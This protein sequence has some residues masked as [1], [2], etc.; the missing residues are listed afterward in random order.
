MEAFK[1]TSWIP[2]TKFTD[3]VRGSR[4]KI[5]LPSTKRFVVFRHKRDPLLAAHCEHNHRFFCLRCYMRKPG[6][7]SSHSKRGDSTRVSV[8]FKWVGLPLSLPDED[9]APRVG[10][11][12][13]ADH[14]VRAVT[15]PSMH[16]SCEEKR[17]LA[18][19]CRDLLGDSHVV[20]CS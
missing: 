12:A 6:G 17:A 19:G 8:K 14:S 10:T 4:L 18:R 7:Q 3:L 13:S 16:C 9:Q 2:W 20:S 11:Q 1:R 5:Y 15:M